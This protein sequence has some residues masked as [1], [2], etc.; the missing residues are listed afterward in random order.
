[1]NLK[2]ITIL[3]GQLIFQTFTNV[4]K[5]M[6]MVFETSYQETSFSLPRF[7]DSFQ[8]VLERRR[9]N[10]PFPEEASVYQRLDKMEL[11]TS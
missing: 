11:S 7:F 10:D 1:M 8:T 5:D 9:Q 4:K 2:A 3:Y 6:L